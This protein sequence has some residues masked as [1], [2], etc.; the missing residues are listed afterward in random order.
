M[1]FAAKLQ[2]TLYSRPERLT[3][4]RA[5][6]SRALRED[7]RESGE[8]GGEREEADLDAV[9]GGSFLVYLLDA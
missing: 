8:E 4:C 9:H 6:S 5:L 7:Q 2:R 3:A 1:S